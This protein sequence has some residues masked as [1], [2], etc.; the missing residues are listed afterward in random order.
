MNGKNTQKFNTKIIGA[1]VTEIK[2]SAGGTPNKIKP[3]IEMIT[4]I[5]NRI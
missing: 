3:I 2:P 4:L 5:N 1:N